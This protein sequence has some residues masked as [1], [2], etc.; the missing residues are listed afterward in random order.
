[1][2]VTKVARQLKGHTDKEAKNDVH[3]YT[4]LYTV[5]TDSRDDTSADVLSSTASD[6]L[7]LP[8]RGDKH[9]GD[10][11][12]VVVSRS[13]TQGK[14]LGGDE[15]VWDVTITYSTEVSIDEEADTFGQ[16]ENPLMRYATL[17]IGQI[18]FQEPFEWDLLGKHVAT[19]LG[20]P[21]NPRPTRDA[22]RQVF[23]ITRNEFQGT[24]PIPFLH[25]PFK[26]ENHNTF[27][28]TVNGNKVLGF[29]V[30][31]LKLDS[32]TSRPASFIFKEENHLFDGVRIRYRI[33]TY[34]VHVA[35]KKVI[36]NSDGGTI[37]EQ[38]WQLVV[39]HAGVFELPPAAGGGVGLGKKRRITH[40]NAMVTDPWPLV[41]TQQGAVV[42]F[43][44]END[45]HEIEYLEF[46]R[47]IQKPWNALFLDGSFPPIP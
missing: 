35:E 44:K 6:D 9:P 41:G 26:N 37:A 34:E 36:L 5:K 18:K 43:D 13:A 25:P 17:D 20:E 24:S 28:N 22:T 42:K 8:F 14:E 38:L 31:F 2:T 39:L 15:T 47:Y 29:E 30:G 19:D 11:A 4:E 12:A 7:D 27:I 40:D 10:T 32:V 1:M 16:P 21:F 23:R 33:V 45:N 3:V 46:Q